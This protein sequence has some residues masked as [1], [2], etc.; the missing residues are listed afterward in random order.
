ME[1]THLTEGELMERF[2]DHLDT[3]NTVSVSVVGEGL[4][5]RPSRVVKL[6]DP[7]AYRTGLANFADHLERDFGITAEGYVS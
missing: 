1:K 3:F 2:D 6:A 7:T 5:L 4:N